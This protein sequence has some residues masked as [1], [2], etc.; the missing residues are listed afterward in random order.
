[1]LIEIIL[2]SMG[3]IAVLMILVI[4]FGGSNKGRLK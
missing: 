4:M 2:K 3:I 1:M